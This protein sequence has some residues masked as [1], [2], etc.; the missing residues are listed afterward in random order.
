MLRYLKILIFGAIVIAA[1]SCTARMGR[2]KTVSERNL[3]DLYNPSKY[4]LHPDISIVHVN[5]SSSVA[6]V[7]IFTAELLFND[8][9]TESVLQAIVR[10]HFTLSKITDDKQKPVFIDSATVSRNLKKADIK[11][12]YV[13][14]LPV[15]AVF[16]SEYELKIEIYDVLRNTF[17]EIYRVV[18]RTSRFNDQNFTVLS[19]ATNYPAF[20]NN[21]SSGELFKIR[22]NQFGFDSILVEYYSL[23]RTLPRPAFSS[24]P[25]LPLK[26][27]PD[28][29]YIYKLSDST[30]YDLPVAGIYQFRVDPEL[31]AGLTL[32]NFGANFPQIKSSDDLLGPL[33]YLTTSAE[34]RD[35]RLSPNLK[36][37]IDNFWLGINSNTDAS[38]EL[39]RIYYNRVLY[40]NLFFSSFKEGWKT[41][42]G[43]IYII[44]GPPRLLEKN[45][46]YE[47]WSYFSRSAG[48]RVEF[49]FYRK[50][51]K[52]TKYDYQLE[53]DV[54]SSSYWREAVNS[55]RKGRVYSVS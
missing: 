40:A 7:K 54:N 45:I 49:I 52:F 2:S 50:E 25:E 51:N 43:M 42:R 41:D 29:S 32:F 37:A 4:I 44:F 27:Y 12:T 36:F 20:T 6:Y 16:G 11:N 39:I 33:V 47:K 23:D 21:F 3:A 18:D 26:E 5:D 14:G 1:V 53:R 38:K 13:I 15:N 28:T 10:F 46:N 30:I 34:F 22:F 17:S 19:A 24:A 31:S 55:W 8:A 9:N 48:S 35:L